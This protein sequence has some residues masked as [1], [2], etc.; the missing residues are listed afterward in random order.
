MLS[1]VVAVTLL[2]IVAVS[3]AAVRLATRRSAIGKVVHGRFAVMARAALRPSPELSEAASALPHTLV[4]PAAINSPRRSATSGISARQ[5]AGESR[6]RSLLGDAMVPGAIAGVVGAGDWL[7]PNEAVL[8]AMHALTHE[9]I[10][11]SLD[12]WSTEPFP[13]TARPGR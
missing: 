11:N 7:T 1:V 12:L 10:T 8:E 5:A 2:T 13:V 4:E 9:H 6:G 3:V